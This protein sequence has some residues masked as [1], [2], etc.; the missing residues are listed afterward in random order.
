MLSA[1]KKDSSD[2]CSLA[3]FSLLKEKSRC[4]CRAQGVCKL[5]SW[6]GKPKKGI[7]G[8]ECVGSW[9]KDFPFPVRL[10]LTNCWGGERKF[11][12]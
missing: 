9:I 7:D 5:V 4:C 1:R 3:S 2:H 6:R 12:L 10:L 8:T 11:S